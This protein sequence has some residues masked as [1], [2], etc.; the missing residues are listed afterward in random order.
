M[1]KYWPIAIS[2][3]LLATSLLGCSAPGRQSGQEAQNGAKT[4]NVQDPY[5][6]NRFGSIAHDYRATVHDTNEKNYRKGFTSN[7][8]NQ[9]Q[10]EL[11][12]RAANDVPGVI[13]TSAVVHGSDAIVGIVTRDNL[14]QPQIRVVEQQ[15]HSAARATTPSLR[16]HVT[17]DPDM[18]ARLRAM[19]A[20]IYREATHR[21][22]NAPVHPLAGQSSLVHNFSVMLNDL[23]TGPKMSRE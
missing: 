17:A 22:N 21:A 5:Q 19:N 23:G 7:G 20:A 11:L 6:A 9:H 15:V 8:F 1:N 18:F 2:S 13:R 10:A 16:I 14:A 12:S 4:Q 3:F